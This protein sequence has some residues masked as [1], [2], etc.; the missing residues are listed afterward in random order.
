MIR[1]LI[2]DNGK[3]FET[4]ELKSLSD[5]LDALDDKSR[6]KFRNKNSLDIVQHT[7]K[8]FL[9][10]SGPGTGK[11]YLFLD[12]ID[13]W[14]Q[15]DSTAEVV[16][17]TFVRKLVSDLQR[18]IY[19]DKEMSDEQRKK[20]EVTT[21]HKLARSIVEKNHGTKK[22]P[23]K[24]HF[25]I[26][27]QYWKRIIWDDALAF[28]PALDPNEYEWGKFE[29]QLHDKNLN[30]SKGWV[31]LREAYLMLSQFY[32][33]VGFADLILRAIKVLRENPDLNKKNHFIVDEYQDFNFAEKTFIEKLASNPKALLVVGDDEQVLYE[34]LKSGKATLIR[35][36][37]KNN[38]YV[39]GM[40]P[41]CSRSSYHI[42]KCADYFIQQNKESDCIEKIYLPLKKSVDDQKI[43]IIGCATAS[44]AVDYIDKFIVDNK[45]EIDKRKAQLESGEK[46]DPFLLILTP[47]R[48]I[49]FYSDAREK[50][51]NI[52]AEYK[53]EIRSF[54]ED[55]YRLLSYY[56]LAKNQHNNFNFRKILHYESIKL[57]RIHEFLDSAISNGNDLCDLQDEEIK[58][59]INK[60]KGI[61]SILEKNLSFSQILE[62]ISKL[63]LINNKT[64]LE[65][66]LDNK[67]INQKGISEMEQEE[68]EEAETAEI[69]VKKMGAV[70]IVTIVGSKGLS[71]EHVI[72]IGFDDVNMKHLTKNQLYVS[73]TRARQSLHILTSLKS[74]GSRQVHNFLDQLPDNHLEFYW[75][76]KGSRSKKKL[77]GKSAI[78]SYINNLNSKFKPAVD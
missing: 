35:D 10:I 38:E 77:D 52:I 53:R 33:A 64:K 60:C 15:R 76:V 69:E 34:N 45:A 30:T 1:S 49:N 44:T 74:G 56:S 67:P 22:W 51:K 71:A 21:L 23:L 43:Q 20:I 65:E 46:R 58:K 42:T 63:I 3:P 19:N 39:N 7:A 28:F 29:V 36:L 2:N 11:S 4:S 5:A 18:D 12:K 9:I 70:D 14:Y 55:Y 16:V 59:I 26:I 40:L 68:D 27:D 6:E 8:K 17:T 25:R 31:D 50:L 75:Y 73:I 57:K 78:K 66:D 24:R 61:E 37:Y 72:I 54:S 47:S 41:F 32:N 62:E 48:E 13:F